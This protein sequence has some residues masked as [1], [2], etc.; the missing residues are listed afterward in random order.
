MPRRSRIESESGYY[1]IITRGINKEKIF[2]G[3]H[4]KE[5]VTT[6]IRDKTKEETCKI[7]AYCIMNNHL[8]MIVIAEKPALVNIM[9]RINIS[10][11][12][13]YNQRHERIGPVFQDRFKSENINNERYLYG[14]LRYIHNNPV[15]AGVVSTAQ[16]Y[17]WSSM[18]EYVYDKPGLVDREI[19]DNIMNR[20]TSRKDFIDFHTMKDETNYLEIKEEVEELKEKRAKKI[21]ED[22][23]KEKGLTEF[24][25]LPNKDELIIKLLTETDLSYRKIADLIGTNPNAV[26]RANKKNRP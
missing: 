25:K 2:E 7:A 11:A 9:K 8:H 26:F 22:Y 3:K 5:A 10:Y 15:K 1:H 12:M 16:E 19:K 21:L 4:E 20:F 23:F 6:L 18:R 24:A 14:A 13:S 17:K